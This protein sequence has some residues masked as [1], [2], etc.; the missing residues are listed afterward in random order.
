MR[1][2]L[3]GPR[4]VHL[5]AEEQPRPLQLEAFAEECRR[6]VPGSPPLAFG[7]WGEAFRFVEDQA[8]RGG[9]LI[10][11]LDEFQYLTASD[12]GIVSTI[13][14]F[15][16]RWDARRTPVMLVLSGSALSFMEGPSS[17]GPASPRR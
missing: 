8:D 6:P 3:T 13:Q 2:A 16:D 1:V 5:Q 9:T 15:W 4:V 17:P 12:P 10:V 14:R 7:D 11:I